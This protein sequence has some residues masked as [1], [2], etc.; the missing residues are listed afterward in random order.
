MATLSNPWFWAAFAALWV[1]GV[2]FTVFR[3]RRARAEEER[4]KAEQR[5][6]MA[7]R[8]AQLDDVQPLSAPPSLHTRPE[9]RWTKSTLPSKRQGSDR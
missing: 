1:V 5:Q 9:D 2:V 4:A 6:K 7:G 8:L 3:V